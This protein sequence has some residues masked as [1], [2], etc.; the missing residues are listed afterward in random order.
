MQAVPMDVA[1]IRNDFPIFSSEDG[2]VIYLDNACQTFRP[3]Q[4]IDAMNEYYEL[5]PACG[6]R[7]VHRLAT[8]VSIKLE[9]AREKVARF[10][11]CDDPDCIIFTRGCTEALNMVAKGRLLKDGDQV[12]TTDMEHNSNHVPWLQLAK[13]QDIR[14]RILETPPSGIF[15]MDRF[16]H[17]LDGTA[18]VSMVH[19]NNITGTSVPAKEIVEEAH[20][21]GAL[22]C[23]DGAQ[24]TPHQ[25]I[26]VKDLDVDIFAFSAHKM[27]GPSGM[28]VLYAKMEVLERMEPLIGGGGGVGLTTYDR[29]EF[30]P[31]PERF[32]SGLMNYSGIIG[33]GAAV[34]YLTGVG[35]DA[36]QEHERRLNDIVTS[37]LKDLPGIS[38]LP[39]VDPSL[40]SGIFSFNLQRMSSHDIAMII[41]EMAKVLIRSGMHCVHPYF[42][43]RKIDGCAR[44]SFYLYNTEDE[45]RRFVEAVRELAA[46][47][48][49]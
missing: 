8:R 19:T 7:S 10:I 12:L 9:E 27:L 37:G 25:R 33:T 17:A 38:I 2:D 39:P 11:G 28:G 42:I 41:D 46:V 31:P 16:R 36:I 26:D 32:E 20:D 47:F 40:R 23:F 48:S 5:Y 13:Y 29:A 1:M 4:V 21:R 6:G 22:V 45:A 34:D 43:T 30:L 49:G 35:M 18:L 14:H 24:S 44:A 15:D 3:R